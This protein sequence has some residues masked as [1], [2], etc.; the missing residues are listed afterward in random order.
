MSDYMTTTDA[1]ALGLRADVALFLKRSSVNAVLEAVTPSALNAI[2]S[3]DSDD[4]RIIKILL[5]IRERV[6]A[7]HLAELRSAI[8][9]ARPTR[10]E[11]IRRERREN[12]GEAA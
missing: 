4:V 9:A 6:L 2:F 10:E 8:D 3:M 5:Q 11:R 12:E 1:E 7:E